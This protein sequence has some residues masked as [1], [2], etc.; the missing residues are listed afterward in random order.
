MRILYIYN[1]YQQSGGENLWVGSE[2]ELMGS[3]GHT[4][5]TYKRDNREILDFHFWQKGSLLWQAS[6]SEQSYREVRDLIRRE[7]PEVAHVYNTLALVTPSVY[8]ACREEGVPVVQTLYNY[9][10]V[11][12][13]ASLLRDG[14]ICEE[15]IDH[16]LWRGVRH[17]CYRGSSLQTASLAWMLHSHRRRGTWTDTVTAYIVPTPFMR[18]KFIQG[19]LP[20]D[21][22]VVKPNFHEPDPGL[23]ESAD[24]S[25]LYIGR[26]TPEK[27]LRT[28]LAAWSQ[29]Q[30]A[31]HLRIIGDGPLREELEA[32]AAR[33]G[34]GK[35]EMLGP[36]SHSETL[37]YLKKASFL[38][39]PSEWYEGFPHVILEAFACGVPIVASRIGTLADIIK[40]GET[41]LL[42]EPGQPADLAAKITWIAKNENEC[43]HMAQN[44]RRVYK[45]EYTAD[46]NY[47]R[48][49]AIYGAAVEGRIAE[50]A[51]VS[52]MKTAVHARPA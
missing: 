22:I 26:L 32:S 18:Q 42:Y 45:T 6:W 34:H 35:I 19:G 25:A 33:E 52:G 28:L 17:A 29:M 27:G 48:L 51:G 43:H 47:E 44:A 2:P 10:L 30:D 31:P 20:G 41:G 13:G 8:Y 24:G 46:R 23:R 4:V 37:A 1:L 40:D 21:K 3:R 38:V 15:C 7:R 16:S 12:P 49:M 9:R 50:L 39:L 11:C 14:H 5:V 36:R